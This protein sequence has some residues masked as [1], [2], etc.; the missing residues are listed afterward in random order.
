[1]YIPTLRCD[2]NESTYAR[3]NKCADDCVYTRRDLQSK[4]FIE[5]KRRENP[6]CSCIVHMVYTCVCGQMHFNI[7]VRADNMNKIR[8]NK[9]AHIR[10]IIKPRAHHKHDCI[11]LSENRADALSCERVKYSK[12]Y[13]SLSIIR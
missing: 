12:K 10:K 8:C 6:Q 11:Y 1:M 5:N 3:A 2:E 7:L 9:C 13:C 4:P